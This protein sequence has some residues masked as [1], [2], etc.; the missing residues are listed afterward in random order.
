[1]EKQPLLHKMFN[2]KPTEK[3]EEMIRLNSCLQDS[4]VVSSN[5]SLQFINS[6]KDTLTGT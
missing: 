2:R 6:N 5:L 1:M 3:G 4:Q